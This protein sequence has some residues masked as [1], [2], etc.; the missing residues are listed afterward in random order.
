MELIIK[1]KVHFLPSNYLLCSVLTMQL[2]NQ[3]SAAIQLSKPVIFGHRGGFGGGFGDVDATW[4]W[5]PPV[6]PPLS[7]LSLLFSPLLSSHPALAATLLPRTSRARQAGGAGLRRSSSGAGPWR[8]RRRCA[9]GDERHGA[10]VRRA[11]TRVGGA[12]GGGAVFTGAC[13]GARK[14]RAGREVVARAAR[15][16]AAREQSRSS[17]SAGA[18]A[19]QEAGAARSEERERR[20]S[21]RR[22]AREQEQGSSSCSRRLLR[23]RWSSA[24]GKHCSN[25]HG[26]ASLH[27]RNSTPVKHLRL[28]P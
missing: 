18:G 14:A 25:S 10:W 28:I 23:R 27:R 19:E 21:G 11:R 24:V 2:Q 26:R 6:S 5:G 16:A 8:R 7:S 3:T 20:G 15:G 12:S 22:A 17:G 9:E 13:D 1:S 4:R